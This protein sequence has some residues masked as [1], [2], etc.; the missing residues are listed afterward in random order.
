MNRAG[1]AV[2]RYT[3]LMTAKSF[4][5]TLPQLIE[6]FYDSNEHMPENVVLM[7]LYRSCE[8]S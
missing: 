2:V 7:M 3:K 5:K 4:N 1:G 8:M 6:K